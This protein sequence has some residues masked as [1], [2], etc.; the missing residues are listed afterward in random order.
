MAHGHG[1]TTTGRLALSSLIFA[2]NFFVQGLGGLWTGSLG[3]VSDSLE[4]LNDAV[5]NLLALGSIRVANRREPCD[6]WSYGWHRIEIFNTLL[7]VLLLL[8]LAGAVLVEAWSRLRHPHPIRLGWAIGFS[9]LGLLLNLAATYVLV[10]AAGTGQERD[11]NLRSAYLHALG[12]SLA[13]V[14]VMAGMVVIHFTGWRWVDPLLAAGIAALILRGAFLLLRDALGILMHRAAFDQE[15]AKG[16]LLRL[17]GILGVEDLRSW[18]VCS[19]LSVCTA[20]IIVDAERLADTEAHHQ[21]IEQ[22]LATRYGVRHLTL[23]FETRAM[24][25]RHHHR[26]LH[27]HDQEASEHHDCSGHH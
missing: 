20:H 19:H 13:N 12:D 18:R 9:A 21:A 8:V 3:L 24:A 27:Q 10:P 2:G 14:A 7:G 5:V 16:E 15:E 4:N 6:R 17:P 1:P 26:F 23:H 11:L 22:L 25:D